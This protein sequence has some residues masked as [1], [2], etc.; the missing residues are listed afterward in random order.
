MNQR[1]G[2]RGLN[3]GWIV[4]SELSVRAP[5]PY[6]FPRERVSRVLMLVSGPLSSGLSV[7]YAGEGRRGVSLSLYREAAGGPTQDPGF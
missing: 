2:A 6:T 1:R 3:D 4:L 7:A 5:P